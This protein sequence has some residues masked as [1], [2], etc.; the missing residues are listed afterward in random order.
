MAGCQANRGYKGVQFRLSVYI[1]E[2][3]AVGPALL[4][5]I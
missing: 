4:A 1:V 5:Q 3:Q 2:G